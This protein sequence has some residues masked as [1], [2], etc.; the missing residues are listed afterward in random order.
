MPD[1]APLPHLTLPIAGMTCASCAGRV[2]RALTKLPGVTQAQVNL[3]SERAEVIGSAL[4]RSVSR[5]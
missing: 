3:A 2:E 5:A 1:S 4:A